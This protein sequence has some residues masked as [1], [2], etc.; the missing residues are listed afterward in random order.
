MSVEASISDWPAGLLAPVFAPET[1]F[2]Q[3]PLTVILSR[4]SP[5][6]FEHPMAYLTAPAIMR[7][8]SVLQAIFDARGGLEKNH[9]AEVVFDGAPL[10]DH[11]LAAIE[12]RARDPL[13]GFA[14][15]GEA[16]FMQVP[17]PMAATTQRGA[18]DGLFQPILDRLGA[19]SKALRMPVRALGGVCG[20]CA[21]T[22]LY[23][24]H[25]F[26]KAK[27]KF[28]GASPVQGA[29]A[30]LVR[31]DLAG[32]QAGLRRT[33]IANVIHRDSRRW[34]PSERLPWIPDQGNFNGLNRDGRAPFERYLDPPGRLRAPANLCL[35]LIRGLRLEPTTNTGR[36]G[37]CGQ[38]EV[39]LYA[40]YRIVPEPAL[41]KQFAQQTQKAL[42]GRE[43][44]LLAQTL[45]AEARHP[46]LGYT[47]QEGKKGESGSAKYVPI[48]F[49]R[50][51]KSLEQSRP[52]WVA[53]AEFLQDQEGHPLVFRQL[54]EAV[55][56]EKDYDET[57]SDRMTNELDITLFG[58]IFRSDFKPNI[59]AVFNEHYGATI[60]AWSQRYGKQLARSVQ[61]L[62]EVV[63]ECIKAWIE[64][65]IRFDFDI[66]RTRDKSGVV[67]QKDKRPKAIGRLKSCQQ[68]LNAGGT[69]HTLAGQLWDQAFLEVSRWLTKPELLDGISQETELSNAIAAIDQTADRLWREYREQ[70][71][72]GSADVETLFLATRA[73]KSY[74]GAQKKRRNKGKAA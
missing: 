9:W 7:A 11:W 48:S 19:S 46:L 23:L 6:R 64:A 70:R 53:L 66:E 67:I 12:E 74:F 72:G 56:S 69:L 43:T 61:T 39:A 17:A 8:S 49:Y 45:M 41:L 27:I 29:L 21:A 63:Q 22:A 18:I 4:D 62:E 73:D 28:Q 15:E 52:T 24:N 16:A 42:G 44:K 47:R 65:A 60:A 68:Y 13:G 33:L 59:Q 32:K 14:L 10:P 51:I 25:H 34:E 3:L 20:G 38:T 1:G 54:A 71:V 2:S 57:I 31:F 26:S 55:E 50:E 58:V 5:A 30:T 35:P 36:C 37:C 40:E